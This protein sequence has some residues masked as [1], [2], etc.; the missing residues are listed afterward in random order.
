MRELAF[1]AQWGNVDH[2]KNRCVLKNWSMHGC[3]ARTAGVAG[4]A[5][6]GVPAP[7]MLMMGGRAVLMPLDAAIVK[8]AGLLGVAVVEVEALAAMLQRR[9]MN[10]CTHQ[11]PPNEMINKPSD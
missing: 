1:R 4:P 6:F 7:K 9:E 3:P 8:M 5:L 10:Y 11:T 2:V